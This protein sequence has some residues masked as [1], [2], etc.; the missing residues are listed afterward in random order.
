MFP[1][2][3]A[4]PRLGFNPEDNNEFLFAGEVSPKEMYKLLTQQW[5]VSEDLSFALISLYGGHIYNTYKALMRLRKLKEDF[6]AFDANLSANIDMCFEVK[7]DEKEKVKIYLRQLAERGFVPLK[8]RNDPIA[9][10]ISKHNVGG[11]VLKTA[12]NVG[13]AKSVWN[14]DFEFGLVPSSQ[15]MRLL[16]AKYLVINGM[17]T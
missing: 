15:S 1:F 3:L 11:V 13:L 17:L 9:E 8:K 2:R 12:L 10:V 6:Y 5:K 4:D 16:I 7:D 14:G